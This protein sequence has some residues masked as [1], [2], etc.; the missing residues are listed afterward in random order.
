MYCLI[1]DSEDDTA[2]YFYANDIYWSTWFTT[3]AEALASNLKH[4]MGA[5]IEDILNTNKGYKVLFK[6][7][8]PILAADHPE[9]LL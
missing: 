7:K 2:T 1:I 6:S 4:N 5:S 9:L 3:A 8:T